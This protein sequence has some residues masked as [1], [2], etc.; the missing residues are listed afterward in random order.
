M[1]T[2]DSDITRDYDRLRVRKLRLKLYPINPEVLD[3]MV[4]YYSARAGEYEDWWERRGRY[5]MAEDTRQRWFAERDQVYRAFVVS[6][7]H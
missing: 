6:V 2:R 3:E 1:I 5:A 7:L 4:E